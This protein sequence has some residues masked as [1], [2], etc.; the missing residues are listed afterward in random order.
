MVL[1]FWHESES[2]EVKT[3]AE[4]ISRVSDSIDRGWD[5]IILIPNKY[6]G[7][8]DTAIPTNVLW[9]SLW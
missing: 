1:K 3:I 2:H 5:I 6:L 4:D 9:E 7:G 8:A